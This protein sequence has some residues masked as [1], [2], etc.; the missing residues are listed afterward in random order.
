MSHHYRQTGELWCGQARDPAWRGAAPT[1]RPQQSCG[2]LSPA[3]APAGA[4]YEGFKSPGRSNGSW[5]PMGP[6]FSTFVQVVIGFLSRS[7][8]K[9]DSNDSIPG[10]P[11]RASP[12]QH[13]SRETRGSYTPYYLVI[14]LTGDRLTMPSEVLSAR[15]HR[16]LACLC[17]STPDGILMSYGAHGVGTNGC[18][19]TVTL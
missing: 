7:N 18:R 5:R 14:M 1:P 3:P 12:P 4:S 11:S 2:T 10:R 13:K 19:L 16:R 17:L 8:G 6:S 9:R 15:C